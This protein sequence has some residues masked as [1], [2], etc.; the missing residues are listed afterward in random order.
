MSPRVSRSFSALAALPLAATAFSTTAHTQVLDPIT[1]HA[2]AWTFHHENVLGT[3]MQLALTARDRIEALRAE[4]ALLATLDRYSS[5]LSAWNPKSEFSRWVSTRDTAVRV[6]PELIEVLALFDHF[7]AQTLGA[8]DASA[9]AA[10]QLW[11]STTAGHRIPTRVEITATVA[12]MQQP[13]WQLD[14]SAVTATR[15]SDTPLALASFTKSYIA[16]HAADAAL[17]HGAR[18][19]M[20]NIGGD[21][22]LRGNL[23]QLVAIAN[24]LADAE[25]DAPL[26]TVLL[27]DRTIATSGSYRRGF[28]ANA[29]STPEFSHIIDP[30][31]ALPAS[32]IVSSTVIARNPA[33]AGALAT[34]FS[35]LSVDESRQIAAKTPGV[36][37]LLIA[38]NGD[39][40]ASEGW[41]SYRVPGLRNASYSPAQAAGSAWNG[42]E[43]AITLELARSEDFRYHRPYVAVWIEDE[44]HQPVRTLSLWYAKDRWLP[45]L[46]AWYHDDQIRSR[47][48]GLT[49]LTN[50][51]SATRPPGKYTLKWDGKDDQGKPVKPGKFIVCI[52]AAREHGDYQ[53]IRQEIDFAAGP[54]QINVAPGAELGAIT[55]DYRKQ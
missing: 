36:E 15:L 11:R 14:T 21:I 2:T 20:L 50:I 18:G 24:P 8:I 34:A 9:E 10:I 38:R 27:R 37:Y 54:R 1:D 29:A 48:Q 6:S 16:D 3:S 13:H 33:T 41:Q 7:R 49:M 12:A 52:E 30:R 39:Q 25:N 31:S 55:L 44:N 22:V 46:R 43:L 51:A 47:A 5:I 19:V 28:S 40:V 42:Y 32:H 26:D 45:E 53:L 35:V 23:A 17:A 4:T